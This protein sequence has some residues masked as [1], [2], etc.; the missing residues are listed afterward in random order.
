MILFVEFTQFSLRLL[1]KTFKF[2]LK[3]LEEQSRQILSVIIL[4]KNDVFIILKTINA[5]ELYTM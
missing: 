4:K 3:R 2:P 5:K 1:F